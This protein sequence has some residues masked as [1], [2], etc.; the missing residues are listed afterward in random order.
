VDW[1]FTAAGA[2]P[3]ALFFEA[4]GF[5]EGFRVETGGGDVE[6]GRRLRRLGVTIRLDERMEV[7]HWKR[8]DLTRL[9]RNDFRRAYGWSRLA[10]D[11]GEAVGGLPRK[12]LANVSGGFVGG[13]AAAWAAVA[14]GVAGAAP[15]GVASAALF[16]TTVPLAA[17]A[18][19]N[20]R[21]WT[22]LAAVES[23]WLAAAALPLTFLDQLAC[24]LGVARAVLEA[25]ARVP[26][27][28]PV[29]RPAAPALLDSARP[30]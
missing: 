22:W 21:F 26:R 20:A 19:C 2:V 1:F 3:R 25:S 23:P 27:P 10:L 4:G 18:A 30:R 5:D 6:F 15:G 24:G 13:V 17:W 11:S 12:G 16:A 7:V 9:L 29:R 8:F 28:L 14:L